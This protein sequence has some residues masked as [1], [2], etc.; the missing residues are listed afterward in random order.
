MQGRVD[1]IGLTSV[2]TNNN[3][4]STIAAGMV[5]SW[6][7][8]VREVA[9]LIQGSNGLTSN[10]LSRRL[11]EGIAAKCVSENEHQAVTDGSYD[12]LEGALIIH[13]FFVLAVDFDPALNAC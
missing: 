1:V 6:S 12:G 4:Q 7:V 5:E 9:R 10:G 11:K 2:G 13:F 8:R 3:S